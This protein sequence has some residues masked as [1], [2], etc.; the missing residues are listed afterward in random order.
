MVFVFLTGGRRFLGAGDSQRLP[1]HMRCASHT[2]NLVATADAEK[3][4]LNDPYFGEEYCLVMHKCRTIWNKQNQSTQVA[5]AI[6]DHFQKKL[7]TP[8]ATR[9]NS[10]YDSVECLI[11]LLPTTE[12]I[13][14]FNAI[15]GVPHKLP[16]IIGNDIKFL[17]N[18]VA[19][20]EPVAVGLDLLQSE[21]TAYLGIFL[22]IV[23]L[24]MA[25]LQEKI[26]DPNL[27]NVR[28]LAVALH[29]GMRERFKDA[30]NNKDYL[31]ASAFHPKYR[32][33]WM[34]QFMAKET[35]TFK[36]ENSSETV[37]KWMKKL[38]F[39]ELKKH[40]Q[41]Q[42]EP[43]ASTA[44]QGKEERRGQERERQEGRGQGQGQAQ[45]QE[46]PTESTST[47]TAASA[48]E[49]KAKNWLAK[50][51]TSLPP[52]NVSNEALIK[53]ANSIVD[54]FI[55]CSSEDDNFSNSVFMNEKSLIDLFVRY[56]T[57]IP[58]SAG[59]ERLFSIGKLI[60]RDNRSRLSDESFKKLM[61]MKGSSSMNA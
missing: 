24:T 6:R 8:G 53:K 59:V 16:Q 22:P 32:V 7:K 25:E 12:A 27:E 60:M 47:G 54:A 18:Y 38:V 58:S 43:T 11:K 4:L 10:V 33:A 39:E 14:E 41:N 56:N 5:D 37:I 23:F 31:L 52:K 44:S 19:V 9:W 50:L 46:K 26:D 20:F 29:D 30:V 15:I 57:G 51:K 61:F 42:N 28:P 35:S 2:Y 45:P 55:E 36:L 13:H 1:P 49:E 34:D 40:Q 48:R 21:R 17:K 3:A